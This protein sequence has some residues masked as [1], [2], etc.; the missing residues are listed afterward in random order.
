[1]ALQRAIV[2]VAQQASLAAGLPLLYP[3]LLRTMA[4]GPTKE[5]VERT[6]VVDTLAQVCR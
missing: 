1:M 5:A 4:S 6:L 3:L 2:S